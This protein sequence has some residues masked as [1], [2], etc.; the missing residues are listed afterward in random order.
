MKPEDAAAYLVQQPILVDADGNVDHDVVGYD[1]LDV[2]AR[3]GDEFSRF[4]SCTV[5]DFLRLLGVQVELRDHYV[6]LLA[7]IWRTFRNANNPWDVCIG[8]PAG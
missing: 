3:P 8:A 2:P 6:T 5:L 4:D 1:R 7:P